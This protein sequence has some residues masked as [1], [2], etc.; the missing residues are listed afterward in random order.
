MIK[1]KQKNSQDVLPPFSSCRRS[2]EEPFANILEEIP[3]GHTAV[4]KAEEKLKTFTWGKVL[5][6]RKNATEDNEKKYD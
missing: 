6:K 2:N 4:P 1:R 3:D 5:C